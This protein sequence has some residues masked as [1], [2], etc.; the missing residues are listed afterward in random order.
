MDDGLWGDRDE[1]ARRHG[2]EPDDPDRRGRSG[3]G[4][5]RSD[6]CRGSRLDA[7]ARPLAASAATSIGLGVSTASRDVGSGGAAALEPRSRPCAGRVPRCQLRSGRSPAN[8][9]RR[10]TDAG[11]E[12]DDLPV[13]HHGPDRRHE[14]RDASRALS[15]RRPSLRPQG[16]TRTARVRYLH[17]ARSPPQAHC[18]DMR[19]SHVDPPAAFPRAARRPRRHALEETR[20]STGCVGWSDAH[21]RRPQHPDGHGGAAHPRRHDSTRRCSR[22]SRPSRRC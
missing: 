15:C 18:R 13:G 4:E 8:A 5:A 20:S 14:R 1:E 22:R 9:Q 3:R 6:D 11:A 2:S 19:T 12:S 10:C 16:R 7:D 21:G 17:A